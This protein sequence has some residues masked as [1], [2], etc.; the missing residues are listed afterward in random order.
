MSGMLGSAIRDYQAEEMR[1]QTERMEREL[2]GRTSQGPATRDGRVI[3]DG[4]LPG[5]PSRL[6]A[7]VRQT[8]REMEQQG[9]HDFRLMLSK[10]EWDRDVRYMGRVLQTGDELF[11]YEM[12]V[13]VIGS[14]YVGVEFRRARRR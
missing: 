3:V 11:G 7:Q 2:F 9:R 8:V 13:E 1:R 6:L 5:P 4:F 10:Q 14:R 12:V